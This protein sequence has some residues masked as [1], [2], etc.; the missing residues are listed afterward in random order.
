M[1]SSPSQQNGRSLARVLAET[2]AAERLVA[3]DRVGSVVASAGGPVGP[4]A[5]AAVLALWEVAERAA[6]L[7]SPSPLDHVVMRT[8]IGGTVVVACPGGF[9]AALA[10]ADIRPDRVAYELRRAAAGYCVRLGRAGE[11]A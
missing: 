8:T 2:P 7:R 5:G 9:V 4:N 10:R 11:G 1:D 3:V 6:A